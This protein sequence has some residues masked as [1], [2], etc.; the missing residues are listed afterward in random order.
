MKIIRK[1]HKCKCGFASYIDTELGDDDESDINILQCAICGQ[2]WVR[3]K[4][5]NGKIIWWPAPADAEAIPKKSFLKKL[6]SH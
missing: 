3:Q 5:E 4:E 1:D 6:L 2:V